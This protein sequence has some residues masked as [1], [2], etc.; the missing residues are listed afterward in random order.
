M[1]KIKMIWDFRGPDGLQ[2]A[3]HHQIHLEEFITT[4]KLESTTG[5]EE[6]NEAYAIAFMIIEEQNMIMVRDTLKP[7]RAELFVENI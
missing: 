4:E 7:H 6:I 5:F 2:I 1:R 3:K